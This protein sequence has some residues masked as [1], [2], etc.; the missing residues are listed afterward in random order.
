[1]AYVF[2]D[3]IWE[4]VETDKYCRGCGYQI[5]KGTKASKETYID[6]K[7]RKIITV[8]LCDDCCDVLDM[9]KKVSEY[10]LYLMPFKQ[11]YKTCKEC[12][13]PC[14][15]CCDVNCSSDYCSGEC[16]YDLTKIKD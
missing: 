7:T 6:E 13:A 5:K 2:K 1:M 12:D 9:C 3:N 11:L 10:T 4:A 15:T 8:Y 14:S 16:K